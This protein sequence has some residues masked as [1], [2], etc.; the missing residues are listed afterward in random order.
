MF[1]DVDLAILNMLQGNARI[2]NADIARSLRMAPSGI[3]ERIRKLEARGLIIGYETRIDPRQIGLGMLVFVFI[4]TDE[5]VGE[6]EAAREIARIPEV[7]E[8]HHV[9]GEDCYFV[10][11]RVEN[12]DHLARVMREGFSR[13]SSI[14]STRTT[15]V[16]ETVKETAQLPLPGREPPG[17]S[18]G[19]RRRR[20]SA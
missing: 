1:D 9:A 14:R 13:I 4:R 7:L 10:K 12:T 8:T 20:R 15:I 17:K 5:R 3:L 6:I 11:L 16:L 2:S 18:G 19:R